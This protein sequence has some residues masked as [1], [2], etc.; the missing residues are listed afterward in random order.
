[1]MMMMTITMMQQLHSRTLKTT[2]YFQ[3]LPL[4]FNKSIV[5]V[6]LSRKWLMHVLEIQHVKQIKG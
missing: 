6:D 2:P 3:S 1:M 5:H 4:V